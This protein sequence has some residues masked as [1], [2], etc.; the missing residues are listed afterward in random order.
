MIYYLTVKNGGPYMKIKK[1]FVLEEV[2]GSYLACATGKL[3]KQFSGYIRLNG[4]GA[5]LFKLLCENDM[6]ESEP[7]SALT[8]EYETD[9]ETAAKDAEAFVKRLSEAGIIE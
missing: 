4:T 3:V 7:V 2:G 6:T 9:S 8:A 5:F 1:G